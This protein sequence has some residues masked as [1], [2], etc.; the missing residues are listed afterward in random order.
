MMRGKLVQC[1]VRDGGYP[2]TILYGTVVP[3]FAH[4]EVAVQKACPEPFDVA[5]FSLV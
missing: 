1:N 4:L 2:Y 5:T 3:G